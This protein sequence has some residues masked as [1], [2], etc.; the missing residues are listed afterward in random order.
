MLYNKLFASRINQINFIIHNI[1]CFE[2][3]LYKFY[4]NTQ[5]VP[6]S[7]YHR[8]PQLGKE[9]RISVSL[10]GLPFPHKGGKL[11]LQQFYSV[12]FNTLYSVNIWTQHSQLEV[13]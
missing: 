8:R 7:W 12:L 5:I 1:I 10:Y 2:N 3:K 4:I 11:F 13:P 6:G 9:V